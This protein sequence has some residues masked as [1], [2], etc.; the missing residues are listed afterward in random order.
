MKIRLKNK[1]GAVTCNNAGEWVYLNVYDSKG[2]LL[3]QVYLTPNQA[4][5]LAGRLTRSVRWLMKNSGEGED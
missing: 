5:K 2:R 3:S 1:A 4:L